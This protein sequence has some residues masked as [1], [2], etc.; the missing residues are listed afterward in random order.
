MIFRVGEGDDAKK[1][2]FSLSAILP[3]YEGSSDLVSSIIEQFKGCLLYTS[4]CV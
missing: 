3:D 4:R 2:A 1:Y